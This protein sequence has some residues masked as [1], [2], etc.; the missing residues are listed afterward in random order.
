VKPWKKWDLAPTSRLK[1]RGQNLP[2]SK[3]CNPSR[4]SSSWCRRFGALLAWTSRA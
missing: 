1:S 4:T 3:V 2:C